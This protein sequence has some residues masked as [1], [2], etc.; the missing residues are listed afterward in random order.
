LPE[1]HPD[2]HL[3]KESLD[4][5]MWNSKAMAKIQADVHPMIPTPVSS[6]F[7]IRTEFS[8]AGTPEIC[9]KG[10]A[11]VCPGRGEPINCEFK[12]CADWATSSQVCL[13]C[14]FES[15]C[16][17]TNIMNI[18]DDETKAK[19]QKEV[20]EEV[21]C[22][23]K[24][25]YLLVTASCNTTRAFVTN[26]IFNISLVKLAPAFPVGHLDQQA[27]EGCHCKEFQEICRCHSQAKT[28]H[29]ETCRF[30]CVYSCY[31]CEIAWI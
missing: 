24:C 20:Y 1:P 5:M 30:V 29:E 10:C 26:V 9:M 21:W 28:E 4:M 31:N 12:S 23:L 15:A 6:H 22:C 11:A 19:L 2:L 13:E 7:Q 3:S 16:Q 8:G 18:V 27:V 14:N 25:N 17:F